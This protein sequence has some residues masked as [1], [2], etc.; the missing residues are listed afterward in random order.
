MNKRLRPVILLVTAFLAVIILSSCGGGNTL[1]VDKVEIVADLL[2]D[3]DLYVEELYTYTVSGEFDTVSRFMDNFGD[4]NIEFFEAYVPPKD[5]ELGNFGFTNLE[6]YPVSLREK[7]GDYSIKVKLKDETR[8]VYVRYRLDQAAVKY[9]DRGELNWTVL[10]DNDWDHHNVSAVLRMREPI[11]EP[12]IA[13]VYDRSGG[14]I[15]ENT[16]DILRYENKLVPKGDHPR[17]K[18]Y[19]PTEALSELEATASSTLLSEQLKRETALSQKFAERERLMEVGNQL[20]RWLT[21]VA[22]AG[23]VYYALSLR[24]LAAWFGGLRISFEEI[25]DMEPDRLVYLYRRGALSRTDVLAGLFKLRRK[26]MLEISMEPLGTRFQEDAKAPK[27]AP[28]FTLIGKRSGL[29]KSERYLLNWLFRG[30]GILKLDSLS[31]PTKTERKQKI[32]EDMYMNRMRGLQRGFTGW[33]ELVKDENSQT[34]KAGV[35][36]PRKVIFPVLVLL[37]LAMLIY[38][39]IADVT[40]W[41]WILLLILIAGGSG[42]LASIRWHKKKYMMVFLVICFF[43]AAQILYDPVVE[44]YLNFVLISM[45]M[46]AFLPGKVLNRRSEAKRS[47]VKRYRRMLARGGDYGI[48]EPEALERMIED[49]ILLGVGRQFLIRARN[50]LPDQDRISALPLWD[51]ASIYAIDYVFTQSWTGITRNSSSWN[52]GGDGDGGGF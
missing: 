25:E 17:L 51:P 38:L 52:S 28:Q 18:A 22:M 1:E 24:R 45:V 19:I 8:Q 2:P 37:H 35:Y 10:M 41:G 30:T 43:A 5:R 23:V 6:R 11:Q 29:T 47:A 20:S 15:T 42:I 21:Y 44:T 36:G 40:A 32:S 46:V 34:I 31:G 26:G 3:G 27:Q 16:T 48:R 39:Y 4:A 12:V 49:A 14:E 13:Y 33:R 9:H 50:K 7:S